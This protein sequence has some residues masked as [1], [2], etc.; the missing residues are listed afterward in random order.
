MCGFKVA[1]ILMAGK[2]IQKT[3][4]EGFSLF[5]R[6]IYLGVAA[7]FSLLHGCRDA[8]KMQPHL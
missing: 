3:A 8:L 7:R 6:D 1:E 4:L 5:E 2:L